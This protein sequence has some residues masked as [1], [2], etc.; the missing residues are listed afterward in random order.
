MNDEE[1]ASR[2]SEMDLSGNPPQTF[3]SL[4]EENTQL[5]AQMEA[6]LLEQRH[7]A[8]QIQRLSRDAPAQSL[9]SAT[10]AQNTPAQT[11]LPS[12]QPTTRVEVERLPRSGNATRKQLP[13]PEKFDG[14]RA[15]FAGWAAQMREKI[16]LDQDLLGADRVIWYGI[17]QALTP[18]V[19]AVV[20]AYY[21]SGQTQSYNPESFLSYL[22]SIYGD[23]LL[24]ERALRSLRRLK[25]GGK[26]AFA[27][28]FPKFERLL[29]D[30][31]GA[32]WPDKIRLAYLED[33]IDQR[34]RTSLATVEMPDDYTEYAKKLAK[35]AW[36]RE[37]AF[38]DF[39]SRPNAPEP[40]TSGHRT[41]KDGDTVMTGR[42]GTGHRPPQRNAPRTT[43]SGSGE[44]SSQKTKNDSR[45]RAKW[46]DQKERDRRLN[47]KLCLRCGSSDHFAGDCPYAPA[48][49][50]STRVA[51]A[52]T[53][54][55]PVLEPETEDEGSERSTEAEN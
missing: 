36:K 43:Q 53:V 55:E 15:R 33:A 51:A 30:A 47:E 35:I 27:T 28:F 17:N 38:E 23:H 29:A 40:R 8:E 21:R 10:T 24:A 3:L 41:D 37:A 7:M 52:T 2:L 1:L 14:D 44:G 46:V 39:R 11:R 31:G 13:W 49:R 45:R 25:Q 26:E 54:V 12:P 20:D 19:Q 16:E 48:K 22:E 18:R 50:P 6:M 42:V 4:S 5:K 9:L 34:L 32:S